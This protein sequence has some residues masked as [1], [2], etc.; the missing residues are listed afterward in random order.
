VSVITMKGQ[1]NRK[2]EYAPFSVCDLV[3]SWPLIYSSVLFYIVYNPLHV[4]SLLAVNLI[5]LS[6]STNDHWLYTLLLD[7]KSTDTDI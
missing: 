4:V 2:S 3:W 7:N 1:H 6:L 5:S